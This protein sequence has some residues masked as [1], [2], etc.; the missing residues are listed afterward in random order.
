VKVGIVVPFSWSYWGGVVEHAENQAKALFELGHEARIVIGNDPPGRLTRALH[1]REGRHGVLPDYVIPVGRTVIVPAAFS[2]AN[3]CLTPQCMP[4]M[5]RIFTRER[6]DV[7]HVHEPM[8]PVISLYA[9]AAA[10]C[11]VVATV[12]SSGGRWCPW[13]RRFWGVLMPRIDYRVAV[14][15]HAQ[16]AAEPWVGGPFEILPNGVALPDE[17]VIGGRADHV[18]FIGRHEARKGLRVLLSAW[19]EIH[20]RTRARLRVIGAD[21]LAVRYLLRRLAISE[22]GIDILGVV[23]AEVRDAE[24]ARAKLLAA[25]AIGAES[26][27]M[28]LTEAFAAGTPVVA[29]DIPGFREVAG[30]ETG[31]L[32]PPDDPEALEGAIIALLYDEPRRRALAVRAREVAEE[33]YSWRGIVSRLLEIYELVGGVQARPE[34]AVR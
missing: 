33:R 31:T 15:E 3:V 19:P 18:V 12:H 9:L 14:S 32:V 25:P 1:P 10:P 2:L 20:R 34:V 27:G 17:V 13:G 6:F 26:F 21:P 4:R 16:C 29:S 23:T 22:D 5:K 24:L 8:A 7:V 28:V 30:P 11:P